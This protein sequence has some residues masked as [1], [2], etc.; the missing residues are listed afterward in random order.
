[1]PERSV[2]TT[3]SALPGMNEVANVIRPTIA[4]TVNE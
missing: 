1:M 4:L 2:R 3:N